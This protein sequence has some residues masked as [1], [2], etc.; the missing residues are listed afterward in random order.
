MHLW[1]RNRLKKSAIL[2]RAKCR[3]GKSSADIKIYK[4]GAEDYWYNCRYYYE[5]CTTLDNTHLQ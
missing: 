5:A 3:S 2:I 1:L 4:S